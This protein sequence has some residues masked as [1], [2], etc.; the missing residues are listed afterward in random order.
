M[1]KN[2]PLKNLLRE[3]AIPALTAVRPYFSMAELRAWLTRRRIPWSAATLNSYLH[4]FTNEG[5]V[6]DAGRG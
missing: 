1:K 4:A 2:A 5:T 3:E 6:H